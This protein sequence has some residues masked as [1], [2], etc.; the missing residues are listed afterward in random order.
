M[1]P[2][3]PGSSPLPLLE[4]LSQAKFQEYV[5]MLNGV[6]DKYHSLLSDLKPVE[7]NLLQAQLAKLRSALRP[8]FFPLNWNSLHIRW[9][10]CVGCPSVC[11][12]AVELPVCAGCH[13]AVR[14]E[15]ERR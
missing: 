6:L 9:V 12:Y 14:V 2:L 7:A 11:A 8:G 3:T 15:R 13:L 10:V 4:W 1:S 5:Q